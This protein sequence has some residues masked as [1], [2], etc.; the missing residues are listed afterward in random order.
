MVANHHAGMRIFVGYGYNE[1]DRWIEEYVLPL[2]AAF[3]CE[4]VHGKAVYGGALSNEVIKAIRTSEA[5]LGFTTRRDPVTAD[6]YRTHEWVVH[7]L[8]TAHAQDPQIPWVEI[9]EEG[10]ISPGGILDSAE[11][12]RI[13]Y[14]PEDR[15]ACLVKIAQALRRFHDLSNLTM[16]RLGPTEAVDQISPLLDDPSFV[17]DCQSLLGAVQQTQR[18]VPVFPIKGGLFV[19]LRGVAQGELVR[20]I[21]SAQGHTWR[22]HY[23]SVD[24]V[25]VRVKE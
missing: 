11:A 2:V 22:S 24:T 6:L 5:V 18:R 13:D 23:E 3:G 14:R 15:A 17:C 12:Q 16:I 8:L 25:D 9:R 4:V 19:Q 1:R 7:E 10:V 20:I 21:I